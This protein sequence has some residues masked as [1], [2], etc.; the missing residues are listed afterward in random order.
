MLE[1]V[2]GNLVVEEKG[3]YSVEKFITARRLMYWQ[4]YLHKTVLAAEYMLIN[5]IRRA[6]ELFL[7][8][9]PVPGSPSLT[10]FLEFDQGV[11]AF[12]SEPVLLE[13][14]NDMDDVDALGE[15]LESK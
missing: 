15:V 12:A 10:G 2:D 7:S 1:I 9:I 11:K 6:R 13:R 5:I 3:I 8:G 4:V 14:F